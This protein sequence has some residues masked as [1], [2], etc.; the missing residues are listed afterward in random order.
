[1]A[2]VARAVAEEGGEKLP[3]GRMVRDAKGKS[4]KIAEVL[5]LV[6]EGETVVWQRVKRA[7]DLRRRIGFRG[8]QLQQQHPLA[9]DR[10]EHLCE[11]FRD[12]TVRDAAGGGG[13]GREA[14]SAVESGLRRTG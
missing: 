6:G 3:L 7:P 5:K 2:E 8:H 4:V 9:G 14:P 12:Q 13:E 10:L 1:M 11:G